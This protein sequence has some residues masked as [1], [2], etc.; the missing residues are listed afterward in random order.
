MKCSRQM[1][2]G[3]TAKPSPS[4]H[5]VRHAVMVFTRN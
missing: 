5:A 2:S 4:T 1:N 3:S